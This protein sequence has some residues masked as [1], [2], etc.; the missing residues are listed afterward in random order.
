MITRRSALAAA[1]ALLVAALPAVAQTHTTDEKHS[2][3][4]R[5]VWVTA[6][7]KKYHLYADCRTIRDF[8][9]KRV[10][11]FDGVK[12]RDLCAICDRRTKKTG[13]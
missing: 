10:E 8:D 7:G 9:P 4:P 11:Y 12:G 13:K 2:N 3:L 5:Y 1:F 6:H